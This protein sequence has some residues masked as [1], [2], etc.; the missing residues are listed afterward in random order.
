M[1]LSLSSE[2]FIVLLH[3]FG[4]ISRTKEAAISDAMSNTDDLMINVSV[5][6]ILENI[7]TDDEAISG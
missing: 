5:S 3:L 2:F 1:W 7:D 4:T 6:R